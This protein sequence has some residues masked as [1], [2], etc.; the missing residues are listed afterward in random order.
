MTSSR[1]QFIRTGLGLAAATSLP[2]VAGCAAPAPVAPVARSIAPGA[3][4]ARLGAATITAVSDGAASSPLADGFVRNATLPQ[5]QQALREAGLPTDR[6]TI[7]FTAFVVEHDGRRVLMDA[8]NGQFG[9]PTAGRLLANLGAAGIDP[10][11]I[12][13]ILIS[14]FHGDH[15]NGL[16]DRDGTLA[17]PNARLMVP[18]PE[19]NFWTDDARRAA[20]PGAPSGDT[21]RR[22][23]RPIA[24]S[25]V[26]FQ[27]DSEL[28]AG[29]RSI[30]AYGHAPGH[31]AFSIAS[32]GQ[33]FAYLGDLTNIA[34]LFVRNPDW[35]VRFD[36]DAEAAR[37]TRRRLLEAA[38]TGD[39]IVGGYHLPAPGLGR[40]V[41]RG[42][43]YDFV[44]LS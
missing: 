10:R 18:A 29:V 28:V 30:A 41:R 6:L 3:F 25:V 11:S 15:I 13:T 9:A 2:L 38:V 34:A 12:D 14:H 17:F 39:W 43:G 7:P 4:R 21:V 8:G 33:T 32:R 5:V 40:I 1:R 20:V 27:P 44:P 37:L 23:F 31:T 16:R 36:M 19:W 42:S 26:R 24:G 22:V 35:A